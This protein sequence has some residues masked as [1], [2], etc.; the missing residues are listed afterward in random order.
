MPPTHTYRA[1]RLPAAVRWCTCARNVAT[2]TRPG[3]PVSFSPRGYFDP[4]RDRMS[5]TA[6][7]I[8]RRSSG[9]GD[10]SAKLKLADVA[11]RTVTGE[12]N[13]ERVAGR[14]WPVAENRA[15]AG[16]DVPK[17]NQYASRWWHAPH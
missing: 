14:T 5:L 12:P 15:R 16:I 17:C 2:P 10:A 8:A 7:L 4:A 1:A 13:G 6:R 11:M 3:R 9:A